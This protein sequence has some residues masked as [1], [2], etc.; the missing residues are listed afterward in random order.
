MMTVG[1]VVINLQEKLLLLFT[2]EFSARI[3]L[4]LPFSKEFIKG[5]LISVGFMV[6]V[7]KVCG[8]MVTCRSLQHQLSSVE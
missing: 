8:V 1:C 7:M 3:C 6:L 5:K 4:C 2:S